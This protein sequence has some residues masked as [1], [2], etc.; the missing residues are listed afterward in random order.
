M[1]GDGDGW[2]RDLDGVRHW[3]RYGAA[4]LLL[5]TPLDESGRTAVLLQL[6]GQGRAATR[7][8]WTIPGGAC[9]SHETAAEAALREAREE[10]GVDARRV[11]VRGERISTTALGGWTYTTVV[12]DTPAP[13]PTRRDRETLALRWIPEDEVPNLR[14][15]PD[16]R[17]AWPRLRAQPIYLADTAGADSGVHSD[18]PFRPRTVDLGPLGFIWLYRSG[19]PTGRTARVTDGPIPFYQRPTDE[20]LLSAGQ[21]FDRP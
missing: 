5:R 10:A 18:E 16:F 2:F 20:L 17:D 9:D 15:H 6:R 11:R 12:A 8:T 13:L 21:V 4:G 7:R 14:L 1:R 3:G 19:A